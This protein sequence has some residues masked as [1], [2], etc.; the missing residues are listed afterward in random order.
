ML[1]LLQAVADE[2]LIEDPYRVTL[3]DGVWVTNNAGTPIP[4]PTADSDIVLFDGRLCINGLKYRFLAAKGL[5]YGEA[6]RDFT[7]RMNKLAARANGRVLD[8]DEEAERVQ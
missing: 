5:E 7:A 1:A 6:M 2:V 8:L 3:G 4:K